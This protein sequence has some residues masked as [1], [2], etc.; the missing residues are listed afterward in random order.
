M[1]QRP[2]ISYK[3]AKTSARDYFGVKKLH[4]NGYVM[5]G[6]NP[7]YL[8]IYKGNAFEIR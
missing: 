8:F 1:K 6:N 5:G 7:Y 2:I 3:D 4:C